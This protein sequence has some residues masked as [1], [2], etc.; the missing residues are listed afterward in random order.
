M[1][2]LGIITTSF[3]S[4]EL[5]SEAAGSFVSDFCQKL[6]ESA[7][8]TVFAP[9]LKS[10]RKQTGNL[11]IIRFT[12]PRLPL[13]NLKPS[14][15][16]H[17]IDIARALLSGNQIIKEETASGRF[18]Y[19]FAL[20]A[21]PSG[22]WARKCWHKYG[23]RYGIW[24]LGS[25]IWAMKDKPFIKNILRE[26]MHDAEHCF[27]DGLQLAR[28]VESITGRR[29][30]FLPSSR[31]FN[32]H[33]KRKKHIKPPYNLAYLGRWHSNKGI[34][35]LMDSLLE[36]QNNDWDKINEVRIRGGGPLQDL[37]NA[38]VARLLKAGRPVSIGGYI[39]KDEAMELL[40]WADYLLIPSRIESIPV[41][42]SDA[43]QSETPVIS[44]PVGDLTELVRKY[45][46][47]IL[48]RDV[49]PVAFSESIRLGLSRSPDCFLAG[50]REN[51]VQFDLDSTV[52]K[53]IETIK[54]H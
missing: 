41:V 1:R 23:V 16:L 50:I 24:A 27:A 5:G 42:F 54:N 25:D 13:S 20:W 29:C 18:D 28:D 6:S 49:T 30:M 31:E 22:Y 52:K 11:E 37:V 51:A 3:P 7:R 10:S 4:G 34:D 14:N 26:T 47:G 53:F 12:V 44:M 40:D 43:L 2:H 32:K 17:W 33:E 19:L 45:S 38:Q 35:I 15:P 48:A 46:C 9:D 21:I 36:L 8:V 39:H